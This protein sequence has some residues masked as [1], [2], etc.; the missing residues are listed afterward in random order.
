MT[1]GPGPLPPPA[2][3]PA[4]PAAL[5][6]ALRDAHAESKLPGPGLGDYLFDVARALGDRVT[7]A[8]QKVLPWTDRPIIERIALYTAL[9]AALLGAFAVLA[10]AIRRWRVSRPKR[11][12]V[13]MS[14]APAPQAAPSG[15]AAWWEAELRRRL[16]AGALRPALEAAWWWTARRLDPP[17]LDATWTTG[18]LLRAHPST[19]LR[20]P[21]RRLDR[22][23]WGGDAPRREEV[24]AVVSEL[25]R[26]PR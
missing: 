19:A 21:L 26:M 22:Q 20:T 7:A 8:L 18:Q 2:W 17:G 14:V 12:E 6:E 1:S 10:V 13:P 15:D 11:V 9:G 24:V 25:A 5:H 4:D 23:L 3:M 16:A